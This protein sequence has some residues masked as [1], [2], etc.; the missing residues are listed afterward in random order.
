MNAANNSPEMAKVAVIGAGIVGLMTALEVQRT[1]RQ[2]VVIDPGEPGG[3]QAASYG[4]GAWIYPAAIMPVSVPGLWRKVLG[5]LADKSGPFVIRWSH[6]PRLVPWLLRFIWAGRNWKLVEDCARV[7]FEL[8]RRAVADHQGVAAE[9]GVSHL[10]EHKGLL[11]IYRDRAEFLKENREWDMRRR[12]GV[13]INELDRAAL[14]KLEPSITERYQFAVQVD[15]AHCRDPNAYCQAIA[16]LI[17]KRGGE[18]VRAPA[19]GFQVSNGRLEGVKVGG[20]V[21]MCEQAVVTAGIGSK[22]LA[23]AA[24]DRVPLETERGYHVV[25]PLGGNAFSH[26]VMPSDGKMGITPTA[27]GLRI[28]G[29]V[30][31]ASVDAAPNWDRAEVL[32]GFGPRVLDLPE[33][34]EKAIDQWMGNRPST[35]DGL[36]CVSAAPSCHGL[37]YGF[38]HGHTGLTQAPATAKLLAALVAGKKPDIDI[39]SMSVKRF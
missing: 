24:G 4:N 36:P 17:Q 16:D 21:I 9:A 5:F 37:F 33:M 39:S 10:L 30:E 23:R 19:T 38:G 8:C 3:R 13:K 35:P 1:G 29:Q 32:R 34:K 12:F 25:L 2:V 28:A 27:K 6:S 14:Q 18:F 7:R 26:P 31:L 15:G 20:K 22:K 11:F